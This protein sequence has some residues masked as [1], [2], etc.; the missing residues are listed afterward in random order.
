MKKME[1]NSMRTR[2]ENENFMLIPCPYIFIIVDGR[3][4]WAK[5]LFCISRLQVKLVCL[6]PN[7]FKNDIRMLRIILVRV[8]SHIRIFSD[9]LCRQRLGHYEFFL[10]VNMKH[11]KLHSYWR[12]LKI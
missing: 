5:A 7:V 11:A 8:L 9:I 2:Y 1:E 4:V 10:Y 6:T 12:L 3:I